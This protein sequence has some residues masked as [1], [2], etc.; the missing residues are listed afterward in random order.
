MDPHK[1][2]TIAIYAG[3]AAGVIGLVAFTLSWNFWDFWDGPMP[4]YQLLLYPGHLTLVYIWHPL[5]TEEINFWPK[6]MLLLFGQFLVVFF[7]VGL[8]MSLMKKL[9]SQ[10]SK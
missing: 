2:S 8:L 5:L 3:I 1:T 9:R 4:G 10:V 6:L 7:V